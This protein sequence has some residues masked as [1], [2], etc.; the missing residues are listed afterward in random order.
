MPNH[1]SAK[2]PKYQ[3]AKSP[4]TQIQKN[5]WSSWQISHQNIGAAGPIRY[6]ISNP[7]R[8]S[9]AINQKKLIRKNYCNQRSSYASRDD[10]LIDWLLILT[11]VYEDSTD[12]RWLLMELRGRYNKLSFTCK[13]FKTFK[14]MCRFGITPSK[15]CACYN[16]RECWVRNLKNLEVIRM[17]L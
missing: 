10:R 2:L 9:K 1:Y 6:Q 14:K 12:G 8:N 15:E 3:C 5:L 4:K 16:T 11:Q 17:H 7:I 13:Y